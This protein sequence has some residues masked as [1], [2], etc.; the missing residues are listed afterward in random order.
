M[1]YREVLSLESDEPIDLNLLVQ[2]GDL[3]RKSNVDLCLFDVED[4]CWEKCQELIL[5]KG[6]SYVLSVERIQEEVLPKVEKRHKYLLVQILRDK[7][8]ALSPS[9]NLVIVDPYL[10][11]VKLHDKTD[12]L[13]TF[14]DVFASLIHD[15]KKVSFVTKPGYNQTLSDEAKRLLANLNPQIVIAHTTTDDFHDRFWIV[16]AHKGLFVGTSLNGIGN[17]YALTDNMRD[18]D[19]E[20]II[21]ELKRLNLIA[22]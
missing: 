22:D 8:R 20:A 21:E 9:N 17:K 18:E 10:F 2:L 14:R 5:E 11:P 12:F 1:K 4:Y 15:I 16:D 6:T 7:L 13:Q 3:L 19:T